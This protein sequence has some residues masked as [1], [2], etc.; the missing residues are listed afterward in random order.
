MTGFTFWGCERDFFE[1]D[2]ENFNVKSYISNIKSYNIDADYIEEIIP[3]DTSSTYKPYVSVQSWVIKGKDI[4]MSITVPD[5]TKELYFGA[6]NSQA[7][8]MGLTFSE[9]NQNTASGFYRLK[10][11]D[12]SNP[13]TASSGFLNY[14]IV[15]SSNKKIQINK[16]DLVVSCRTANGISNKTSMP[17]EVISIAPF[18]ESLKVGFRPL[19]GYT[20]TIE[21][22]TPHG[23]NITY[24]YDKN[25][26]VETFDNS[27]SPNSSLSY[28]SGLDF[29]WIDFTDPDFGGY[30]MTTTIQIDLTGSTQYIYLYLAIITEGKIEQISLDADVQQTGQNTAI[31]TANLGFSYFEEYSV[32]INMLAYRAQSEYFSE[33]I[34]PES[35]EIHPGVGIRFN[36]DN[37]NKNL[38]KVVLEV[39]SIIPP[40]EIVYTLKRNNQNIKVWG[41]P[42]KLF[43]ILDNNN[44]KDLDFSSNVEDIYIENVVP[45]NSNLEFLA[46]QN[47][48]IL[49]SDMIVFSTLNSMI[50]VLG[51]DDQEPQNFTDPNFGAFQ[52]GLN[53]YLSGYD[54]YIYNENQVP[55]FWPQFGQTINDII[56]GI[57]NRDIFRLGVF[58][59]SYGGGATYR[60]CE[61]LNNNMSAIGYFE[62]DCTGYID[63]F[64][65]MT[66]VTA[67]ERLPPG[68]NFH[69]N[70]YQTDDILLR[71]VHVPGADINEKIINVNHLTIDD[72]SIVRNGIETYMKQKIG[73]W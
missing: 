14:Q 25:T 3:T 8:Y 66:V 10:L 15:L 62:I 47:N 68:S 24:S 60:L 52:I 21:I 71:G 1:P 38:I 29:N 20:Y 17:M 72:N 23:T 26:G 54:V 56:N 4:L 64:Q 44:Q 73:P 61:Y 32:K 33:E 19:S 53:L 18:Q 36:G 7:E 31:G 65:S 6:I 69:V 67:E 45:G 46:I 35:E 41:D 55:V 70:Y 34:V 50:I 49:S 5:D 27:Q 30:T 2:S 13:D 42:Y 59:Y 22:S 39:D 63:A 57:N 43:P 37:K 58:G 11:D 40:N 12:I 51:G 48:S 9:S 28:D 16:F